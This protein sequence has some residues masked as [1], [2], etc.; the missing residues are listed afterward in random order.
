[1]KTTAPTETVYL[2]KPAYIYNVE[3]DTATQ[4]NITVPWQGDYLSEQYAEAIKDAVA[5]D[6]DFSPVD[7][8]IAG[9]YEH[10]PEPFEGDYFAQ[11]GSK[12]QTPRRLY[13]VIG[14]SVHAPNP[15]RALKVMRAA[16]LHD[17]RR[18]L[19]FINQ[20]ENQTEVL[21]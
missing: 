19:D 17:A 4:L 18:I 5:G 3:I 14:H 12:R 8:V 6:S 1:M 9:W 13:N 16:V 20:C 2:G 11:S 21:P 7:S 15:E 10:T